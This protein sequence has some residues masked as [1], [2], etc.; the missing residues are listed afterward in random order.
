M[1]TA[2]REDP[3]AKVTGTAVKPKDFPSML[4]AWLPEIR[5]ALPKHLNA[6]RMSRIALT[7]FR[8]TPKLANCDPRSV[9]AAVIQA[10]QL[11]LEPDTLG[12]SYLIPYGQECQFVPGWK[13]LVDLMNRSG[14]GS[15]YTGVIFKDQV[16]RFIDG[17]KRELIIENETELVDPSDI[18]HAYA[19]GHIKGGMFPVIELWRM[20]KVLKHRDRYNKVGAKHYSFSNQEMYARK[21]VLL[22]VLKYMPCSPELATAMALNDAAEMG[23][24]NLKLNEAIEGTWAPVPDDDDTQAESKEPKEPKR[25]PQNVGQGAA[26]STLPPDAKGQASSASQPGPAATDKPPLPRATAS[27]GEDQQATRPRIPAGSI[28]HFFDPDKKPLGSLP[29]REGMM[30]GATINIDDS[31]VRIV[32]LIGLTDK[33]LEWMAEVAKVEAPST[34]Q[35]SA[36]QEAN[37][38]TD[39]ADEAGGPAAPKRRGKKGAVNFGDTV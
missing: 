24:Q 25:T 28:V 3:L 11:G 26:P 37:R 9:F 21:V 23:A 31:P 2:T 19:I 4:T 36:Q 20:A 30:V 32:E 1:N 6:D 14:Q 33:P 27:G 12:R 17:S 16:Y 39:M 7:A 5:R 10:S 22:Q 29:Y 34:Q 15:V 18:T 35:S 8:R 13:G 38:L